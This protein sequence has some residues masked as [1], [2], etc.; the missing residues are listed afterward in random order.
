[1]IK[2]IILSFALCALVT[3]TFILMAQEADDAAA[4][5]ICY[6]PMC[7]TGLIESYTGLGNV[8]PVTITARI[9]NWALTLLGTL[10]LCLIIYAGAIWMLARGEEQEI[11]KAQEILKGAVIGFIIII[12]SYGLAHFIFL[13]LTNLTNAS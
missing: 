12:A 10:S 5:E 4:S 9:I 1:M 3:P 7:E 13:N 2:K 11:E 6:D 8:H